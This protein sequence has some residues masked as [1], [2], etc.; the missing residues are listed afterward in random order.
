V[1]GW[2]QNR[3]HALLASANRGVRRTA[4]ST[5]VVDHDYVG[6]F[7]EDLKDVL[8]MEAIRDAKLK[9]G[10]DPLG[11]ASLNYWAPIAAQYELNIQVV[12][13][14]LDPTFSFMTMMASFG[15]TV[16]ARM[17]WRVWCR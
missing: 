9:L 10:A 8:D 13:P 7:V 14:K 3:A 12:N 15:W 17:R 2:I 4:Y 6:P 16:R 5:Y 1:T 11:G